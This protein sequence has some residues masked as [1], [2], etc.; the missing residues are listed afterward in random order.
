MD[1]HFIPKLGKRKIAEVEYEHIIDIT[2]VLADTPSEQAHALPYVRT[3]F[4]WWRQPRA[5]S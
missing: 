3:F 5:T 2:D 4:K 1:K